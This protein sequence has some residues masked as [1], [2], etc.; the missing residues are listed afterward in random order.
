[1]RLER[2]RLQLFWWETTRG[3]ESFLFQSANT[4]VVVP[5]CFYAHKLHHSDWWIYVR[6]VFDGSR[7]QE[8]IQP[9][10]NDSLSHHFQVLR[11]LITIRLGVNIVTRCGIIISC[12]HP[13]I[14]IYLRQDATQWWWFVTLTIIHFNVFI[15]PSQLCSSS[16][17]S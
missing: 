13:A 4:A 10:E 6:N 2:R 7:Q 17:D 14:T 16:T 5:L 3:K 11:F 9:L 8:Y 1:M 12:H 15:S